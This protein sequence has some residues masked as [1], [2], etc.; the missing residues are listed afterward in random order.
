M[1]VLIDGKKLAQLMIIH[2]VGR[3]PAQTYVVK[4]IDSDSFVEE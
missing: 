3:S 4:K 2:D 1:I